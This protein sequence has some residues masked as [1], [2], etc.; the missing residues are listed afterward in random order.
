MELKLYQINTTRDTK[1]VCFLSLD[2]MQKRQG[3][4]QVNAGIYD[5]VYFGKV[6]ADD[7]ETVYSIFNNDSPKDYTAGRSLSV[8]DV[9]ETGGCF[10]YCDTIGFKEIAF[11]AEKVSSPVLW[12]GYAIA[13]R[14][15]LYAVTRTNSFDSDIEVNLFRA[16]EE[17]VEYLCAEY[18]GYIGEEIRNRSDLRDS[19]CQV[20]TDEGYAVIEW[21]DGGR[22]E[23]GIGCVTTGISPYHDKGIACD[24]VY[25]LYKREWC[26]E[27]GWS[28]K[29]VHEAEKAD[30]EYLGQMYACYDEF[31]ETEYLIDGYVDSLLSDVSLLRLYYD[32]IND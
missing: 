10:Y 9:V 4:E 23:F 14:R 11:D 25:E 20:N 13:G 32:T 6:E 5:L 29:D 24:T 8:S 27:R 21:A 1:S 18:F 17:A 12:P 19:A 7:L 26:R 2:M 30:R 3:S 31:K 28:Y 16:Y 22:T 15:N